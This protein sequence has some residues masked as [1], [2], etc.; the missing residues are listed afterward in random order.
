LTTTYQVAVA[1]NGLMWANN[2]FRTTYSNYIASYAAEKIEVDAVHLTINILDDDRQKIIA[3]KVILYL[4]IDIY[5]RLI[6]GYYCSLEDK[7]RQKVA[8]HAD[9]VIELLKRVVSRS[10]GSHPKMM[11]LGKPT[12]VVCD[13]GAAFNNEQVKNFFNQICVQLIVTETG[14]PWKKPFIERFN[15]TLR[16]L[17]CSV[18]PQ[19]T[20][21]KTSH[22]RQKELR[23]AGAAISKSEFIFELE[24]FLF[25]YYQNNPHM[26][27]GGRTPTEAYNEGK[28][29]NIALLPLDKKV[30]ENLWANSDAR[31][32]CKNKG[33]A[34]EC[35][36]YNSPALTD[37]MKSVG[38][39]K[40]TIMFNRSNAS[41]IGVVHPKL[42]TV[43]TVSNVD[44]RIVEGTTIAEAKAIYQTKRGNEI[45]QPPFN[46]S[47]NR[48]MGANSAKKK[49]HTPAHVLQDGNQVNQDFINNSLANGV[50]HYKQHSEEDNSNNT[51]LLEVDGF[52]VGP[53]MS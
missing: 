7:K 50:K 25:E 15:R 17:L 13:A 18:L 43:L 27:L 34:F 30:L 9:A 49:P 44:P 33:I 46:P 5:T 48:Q 21:N 35:G 42:R 45:L 39:Q 36:R 22:L 24:S 19:Y 10:A 11:Y 38:E 26:G 12:V 16:E 40:V 1:R 3:T 6:V 31:A 47:F 53:N 20:G 32:Y 41:K 37:F 4:A 28:S 52:P 23:A 29:S 2:E 8:E 51:E 14:K